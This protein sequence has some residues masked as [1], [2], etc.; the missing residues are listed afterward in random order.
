MSPVAKDEVPG[1]AEAIEARRLDRQLSPTAF[2]K[3]AGLTTQGLVPVRRGLRRDYHDKVRTG[4]AR[5]LAW[6][7]DWYDRIQAGDTDL[8]DTEH[9]DRPASEA[10]RLTVLEGRVQRMRSDLLELRGLLE[11]LRDNP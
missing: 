6:P 8:P 3:A 4:V 2:A 5:A 11:Q 7:L 9:P 10:E 1:M